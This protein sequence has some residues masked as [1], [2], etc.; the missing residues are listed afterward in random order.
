MQQ[1]ALGASVAA[2]GLSNK[3]VYE[4]DVLNGPSVEPTGS[5]TTY[6]EVSSS[7][8]PEGRTRSPCSPSYP[9]QQAQYQHTQMG[10]G[11]RW[12]TWTQGPDLAPNPM[13]SAVAGPPLEEHLAQSTLWPE[14][15]KLY[16]HANH[17]FSMAADPQGI[18][19]ASACKVCSPPQCLAA[20]AHW[21]GSLCC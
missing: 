13:P 10:G 6:T 17:I 16:G 8:L 4:D 18:Y 5:V 15:F 9:A 3:A 1:R 11:T 7:A 14:V 12:V 21:A 19:L 2:L 20:S